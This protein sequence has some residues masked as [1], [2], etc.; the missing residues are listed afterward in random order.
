MAG[1]ISIHIE[2]EQFRLLQERTG[3]W[4]AI[5]DRELSGQLRNA[6]NRGAR[7]AKSNVLG[8]SFPAVPRGSGFGRHSTGL[9]QSLAASVKVRVA[10]Q[11]LGRVDYRI[12]S[13]HPMA[14]PTNLPLGGRP[15]WRH[16]LFGRRGAG[17][18]FEQRRSPWWTNAIRDSKPDMERAASEALERAV[19]RF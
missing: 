8:A 4:G 13:A 11:G 2:A 14:N 10:Q 6:A 19:K 16:P 3:R 1:S 5:L 7:R 17:D 12:T 15:V 9:R 18:F